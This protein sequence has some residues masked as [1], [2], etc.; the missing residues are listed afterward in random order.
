[1]V[2]DADRE[3]EEL[4][5][6]LIAEARPHDALLGEEGAG[7]EGTTGLRWV[8]DP[9]DG[10]T[11][12]VFGYPQWA[13][14]IAVED[15]DGVVAGAIH[16]PSRDELFSAARGGGATLNG[17]PIH[18][19]H[20]DDLGQALIGTGFSYDAEERV[21]QALQLS[22]VIGEVRDIRRGGAA[23]IDIAWVACGRLDGYWESG[24]NV[25]DWAAGSLLVTEA[26]GRWQRE[27]GG[28]LGVDQNLA[29][30]PGVFDRLAD[31][32]A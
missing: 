29:A 20:T 19:R 22:R 27:R 17:R 9:L 5:A 31:L 24:L 18:V 8:V 3:A 26:G 12:F 21:Q 13:V 16:D 4:L 1:M 32:I 2:S 30:C 25:W 11:N 14:S 10:T 7:R 6:R 23:A 28:P 15:A